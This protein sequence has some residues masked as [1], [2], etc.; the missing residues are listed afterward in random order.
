[1]NNIAVRTVRNGSVVI[2]GVR[3]RPWAYYAP[4]DGRLDGLRYA[5]GRYPK[6]GAP[7]WEPFVAL[8]CPVEA[9]QSEEPSYGPECVDGAFPW[10]FW[11]AEG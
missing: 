8:V 10:D 3:F 7:G 9:L 2:G 6:A 5:F 4:Y 1:M 11:E